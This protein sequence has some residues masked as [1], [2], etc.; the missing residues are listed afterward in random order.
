MASALS[1]PEGSVS[2]MRSS[3]VVS[4]A[5]AGST[6]RKSS[7]SEKP[8]QSCSKAPAFWYIELPAAAP[9]R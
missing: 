7:E 8:Y 1:T 3:P 5:G 6:R 9:G 2:R 4:A